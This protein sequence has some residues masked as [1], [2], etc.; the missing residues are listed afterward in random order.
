MV[1]EPISQTQLGVKSLTGQIELPKNQLLLW[2]KSI[3]NIC[4]LINAINS[5]MNDI[6]RITVTFQLILAGE[7]CCSQSKKKFSK[8]KTPE[9]SFF[10]ANGIFFIV[11]P[12]S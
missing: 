1:Q 6:E 8:G 3:T 11:A 2:Q 10:K 4:Q 9:L 5:N 12:I 7:L